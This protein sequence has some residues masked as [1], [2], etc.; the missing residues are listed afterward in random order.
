[1]STPAATTGVVFFDAETTGLIDGDTM[2][3]IN[4]AVVTPLDGPPLAYF[5]RVPNTNTPSGKPLTVDGAKRLLDDLVAAGTVVSFNGAGF[6]FRVLEAAAGGDSRAAELAVG[7]NHVD[8]MIA[9][10]AEFGYRTSMNSLAVATLTGVAKSNTGAWAAEAF[11]TGEAAS[12]INYCA[13]DTK[14]LRA[15]WAHA[16]SHNKLTCR[17]KKGYERAWVTRT[18]SRAPVMLSV[19]DAAAAFAVKKAANEFSWM[20]E[21]PSMDDALG[22]ADY[23]TAFGR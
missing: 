18:E 10:M 4:C 12:V 19:P 14:V 21:P 7:P 1:M 15:L 23:G 3:G 9:W 6:D 2:P 13:D 20:T 22:W 17:S 16:T 5:D 8:M 11:A